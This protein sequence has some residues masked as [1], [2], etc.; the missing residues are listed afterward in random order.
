MCTLRS[1]TKHARP[2]PS[3]RVSRRRYFLLTMQSSRILAFN[4]AN[5]R[6]AN[7]IEQSVLSVMWL[8][9]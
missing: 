7:S 9:T 3:V 6:H 1:A 8:R 2:S 5:I 4:E